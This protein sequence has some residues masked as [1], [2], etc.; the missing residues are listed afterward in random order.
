MTISWPS[1]RP[2]STSISV[3]PVMPV[4]TGTNLALSL[5]SYAF[6][7]VDALHGR[8]FAGRGGTG[9]GLHAALG[10]VVV[11]VV[12]DQ[13]LDG[14]GEHAELVGGSDFG[15]GGEA[16]PQIGGR[17]VEGDDD[18]KVLGFFSA[19][20]GLRGGYAGGAEQGLVA[21]QGYMA[22]ENFAGQGVNGDIGRLADAGC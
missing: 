6:H 22:F 21:G 11:R 2:E 12:H 18:L 16:G 14:Q 8:G 19:G 10:L 15:S 3:A 13:G 9:C 5:P 7:D 17:I 20:G 1:F 4:V